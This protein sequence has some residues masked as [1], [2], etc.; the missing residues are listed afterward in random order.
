MQMI[1]NRKRDFSVSFLAS[2]RFRVFALIILFT[3]VTITLLE[4]YTLRQFEKATKI[5]LEHEGLLLSDT[6]EAI[7]TPLIDEEKFTD[8]QGHIDRLVAA[9]E[10]NDIEKKC[11]DD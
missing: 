5:E 1:N 11:P 2:I 7:I 4:V 9:R 6:L 3:S 8:I 10:I